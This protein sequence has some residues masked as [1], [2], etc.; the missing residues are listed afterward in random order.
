M[1]Y[2]GIL[3]SGSEVRTLRYCSLVSYESALVVFISC[4]F[5]EPVT[6]PTLDAPRILGI[7]LT[8]AR[9][10]GTYREAVRIQWAPPNIDSIS[11]R[12]YTLIRKTQTDSLFDIFTSTS[13][14]GS[15]GIPDSIRAIDDDANQIGFPT[16]DFSLVQYK[17]FAVDSLGRPSDTSVACSLYLA[18]QPELDSIDRESWRFQWSSRNIQGS[19]NSYM[20]LWNG[21][22]TGEWTS[23]A[24]EKFGNENDP[25]VFSALLPDSLSPLP[26]DRW[27]IA[28]F[29]HA[30]GTVHQSLKV[31]SLDVP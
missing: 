21:S 20:K 13:S 25:T 1:P 17:I 4:Q 9:F 30:M 14:R 8:E 11:L 22:L 2:S 29:F 27:Y 24:L 10:F 23:D 26:S 19:I 6:P 16:G 31:D 28:I 18:P 12:S 7:G 15:V 3:P 5:Y